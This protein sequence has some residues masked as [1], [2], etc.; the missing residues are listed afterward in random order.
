MCLSLGFNIHLVSG[1]LSYSLDVGCLGLL[2]MV[3]DYLIWIG[4]N[5]GKCRCCDSMVVNRV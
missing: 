2:T 4:F 1:C 3:V 5:F